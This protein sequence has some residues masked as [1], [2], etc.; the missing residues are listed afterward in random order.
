MKKRLGSLI[1]SLLVLSAA[2]AEGET[3]E[4]KEESTTRALGTRVCARGP[5][6][7]GIDVSHYQSDNGRGKIDW[8]AVKDSGKVF[9]VAAI[10][11]GTGRHAHDPTFEYNYSEIKRVG[12]IRGAYQFLRPD[13]DIVAQANIAVAAV[14][15]LG[16]GDLPVTADIEV[17]W[18]DHADFNRK[19]HQWVEIVEAGTGKR[20]MIYSNSRYW[21]NIGTS[22]FADYPFWHAEYTTASC[23]ST[24]PSEWS[25][26]TFWQYRG[27]EY[28]SVPAGRCPGVVG[29]VDLDYFNG[30]YEE[31]AAFAG[32]SGGPNVTDPRVFDWAFYVS[33]YP[34]VA[35]AYDG[36]FWGMV[37]HWR[38][39]GVSEERIGAPGFSCRFYLR[40]YGDLSGLRGDC[41]AAIGH[42][43]SNGMKEARIASPAFD[44]RY[45]MNRYQDLPDTFGPE[46]FEAAM[47]HW[48]DNGINEHRVAS[49][50]FNH[51]Y[52]LGIYKDLRDNL[53]NDAHAALRHFLM[54]GIAEGR[55]T[56]PVYDG[57][58]YLNR[59]DDLANAF[60][61]KSNAGELAINHWMTTGT[62]ECRQASLA[63]D[64]RFYLDNY[65]DL[66]DAFRDNCTA[67]RDHYL[68]TLGPERRAGSPVF[69]PEYYLSR[70]EDV[71]TQFQDDPFK[72]LIHWMEHGIPEG[73]Q[74][75]ALF[76]P[77]YYLANNKDVADQA[78]PNKFRFAIEHY[79]VHGRYEGRRGAPPS[80]AFTVPGREGDV[81]RS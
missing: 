65:K 58:F 79:L 24:V 55:S 54:N 41:R 21:P 19:L 56:S 23:P 45:Y 78:G 74:G 57:S 26:W 47:S 75:S 68:A 3:E 64:P 53:G 51:D 31:L 44:P 70:Y 38:D 34:D 81:T 35:Q 25:S 29:D 4:P 49:P 33:A 73:R 14:G 80:E 67:A 1:A 9:A 50:A 5:V 59:W 40:T 46:N 42:F 20:P 11:D 69:D 2:C 36:D 66:K 8:Q 12:L 72:A 52:Y 48:V 10:G 32:V 76:D 16:P 43:L 39:H 27:G 18:A 6:V 13:Q 77:N 37:A 7:E 61:G 30:S 63:F 62:Q 60:N 71:R 22:D 17:D 15:R 28:P